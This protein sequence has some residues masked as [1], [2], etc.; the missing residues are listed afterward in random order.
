MK[1]GLTKSP[2]SENRA[3][4]SSTFSSARSCSNRSTGVSPVLRK[5]LRHAGN[6]LPVLDDDLVVFDCEARDVV[7]RRVLVG[8]TTERAKAEQAVQDFLGNAAERNFR[9]LDIARV[10]IGRGTD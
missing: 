7:F 10:A 2:K 1:R 3:T 4:A 9:D 5:L 6:R 8:V